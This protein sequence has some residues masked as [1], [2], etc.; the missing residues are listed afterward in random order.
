MMTAQQEVKQSR[1]SGIP[2]MVRTK[3]K[4]AKGKIATHAQQVGPLT[5]A[6][7]FKLMYH[8][9]VAVID[10]FAGRSDATDWW[11][12]L[13]RI[14]A[15]AVIAECI[16]APEVVEYFERTF[17][18]LLDLEK[19][20]QGRTVWTMSLDEQQ[21]LSAA[22]QQCDDIQLEVDRATQI[23]AYKRTKVILGRINE[24]LE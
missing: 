16:Y 18:L 20:S 19:R 12:L 7:H 10:L 13:F 4:G 15:T 8:P 22:I 3:N 5:K 1:V 24:A 17:Q 11:N 2:R 23:Y 14:K 21:T 9:H 6:E